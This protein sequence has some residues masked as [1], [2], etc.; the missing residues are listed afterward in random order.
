M[1]FLVIKRICHFDRGSEATEWR[2]LLLRNIKCN[3]SLRG[4]FLRYA[5]CVRFGRND[6]NG[7]ARNNGIDILYRFFTILSSV[8]R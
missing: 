2:N 4:R 6:T 3:Y 1:P 8:F 7:S 5:N